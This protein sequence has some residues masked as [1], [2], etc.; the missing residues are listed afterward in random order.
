MGVLVLTL[1]TWLAALGEHLDVLAALLGAALIVAGVAVLL[2]LGWSLLAAG[3]LLI[4]A[5]V[6]VL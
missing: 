2:G 4:L 6:F 1:R 3:L 5:G